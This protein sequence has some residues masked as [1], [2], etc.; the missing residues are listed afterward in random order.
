VGTLPS[1]SFRVATA[2]CVGLLLAGSL[3]AGADEALRQIRLGAEPAE[4][5][6]AISDFCGIATWHPGFT[7]CVTDG[8]R[9]ILT[10]LD[11]SQW[12]E[13]QL[14]RDEGTM[15]YSYTLERGSL[16]VSADFR[17]TLLVA[18]RGDFTLVSWRAE[19]TPAPEMSAAVA[20]AVLDRIFVAGLDGL[21]RRLGE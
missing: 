14:E 17:A 19:F 8:D 15:R 1:R 5:W 12:I 7:S 13:R 18:D 20:A 9:R 3:P 6:A 16:P 11:G 4:V 10:L 21:R 2:A